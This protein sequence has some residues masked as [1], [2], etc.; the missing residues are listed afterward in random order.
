MRKKCF[1]NFASLTSKDRIPLEHNFLNAEIR[2]EINFRQIFKK[3]LHNHF[4][5]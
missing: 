4:Y 1:A 2:I 5:N 3:L